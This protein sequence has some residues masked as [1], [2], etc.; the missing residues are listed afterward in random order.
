VHRRITSTSTR[1][2]PQPTQ[3]RSPHISASSTGQTR[4]HRA[5]YAEPETYSAASAQPAQ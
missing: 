5:D 4:Q 3:Y 1:C 2:L